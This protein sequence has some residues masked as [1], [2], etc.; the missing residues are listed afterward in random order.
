MLEV[1]QLPGEGRDL[2]L[3]QDGAFTFA[4]ADVKGLEP[5]SIEGRW[6]YSDG[7]LELIRGW[8]SRERE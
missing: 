2:H 4:L 1:G 6:T 7:T 3:K 5:V 8:K